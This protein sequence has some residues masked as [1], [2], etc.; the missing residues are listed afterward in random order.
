MYLFAKVFFIKYLLIWNS[1]LHPVSMIV[2]QV[3]RPC[4]TLGYFE[5]GAHNFSMLKKKRCKGAEFGV[6]RKILVIC[7][8]D[9]Y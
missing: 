3:L 8:M 9:S 6:I 1:Y 7:Y 5:I 2:A 4:P